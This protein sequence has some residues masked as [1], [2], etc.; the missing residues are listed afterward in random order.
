MIGAYSQNSSLQLGYR[1][2]WAGI[3][4]SPETGFLSYQKFIEKYN[5][6][7]GAVLT[8][9]QLGPLQT[10]RLKLAYDYQIFIDEVRNGW[11]SVGLA[12]RYE[13]QNFFINNQKY[14]DDAAVID[15]SQ[16]SSRIDVDGGLSYR[17][18]Y[19]MIG[20]S[21]ENILEK[22]HQFNKNS[23]GKYNFDNGRVYHVFM[24]L[25]FNSANDNIRYIP[26]ILFKYQ[27]KVAWQFDFSFLLSYKKKM[28]FGLNYRKEDAF[29]L[30]AGFSIK[31][32]LSLYYSYDFPLSEIIKNTN[33]S[34]EVTLGFNFGEN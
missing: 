22:Q 3:Q 24:N 14:L 7:V 17:S 18:D 25:M 33:G 28:H 2:Q 21:V 10:S 27:E 11:L 29:G 30:I 5:S 12:G 20:L 4:S 34:H 13:A 6:G 19:Y 31:K 1:K 32:K 8:H 15:G 23:E 16:N 26:S 9:D